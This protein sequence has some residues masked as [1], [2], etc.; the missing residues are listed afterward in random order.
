MNAILFTLALLLLGAD[1]APKS[2]PPPT[3]NF[4]KGMRQY[5]MGFLVRGEK[6]GDPI[7]K[8]ELNRLQQQHLAYIRAQADAGK[9]ALAGPLLDNDRIRGIL[10]INAGSAEDAKNIASGDPMVK[11][12]RL[13]VEIHPF[14]VADL[15]CVFAEYQKMNPTVAH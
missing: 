9:Y 1:N 4:P 7:A 13:A 2:A 10:M 3:P 12:G 8:D 5:F 15:S 6:N 14:M 11:S